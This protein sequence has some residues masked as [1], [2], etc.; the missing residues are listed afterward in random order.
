M[1]RQRRKR[2]AARG[3]GTIGAG[4]RTG[5]GSS[6]RME[7]SVHREAAAPAS[8]TATAAFAALFFLVTL[9]WGAA[10]AADVDTSWAMVLDWAQR[11]GLRHGE[12]L[13][14]SYGPLGYLQPRQPYQPSSFATFFA[15]Q[16]LLGLG[17]AVIFAT[18]FRRLGTSERVAFALLALAACRLQ[19][20]A[21]LLGSAMLAVVALAGALRAGE[22]PGA[23]PLLTLL[24]LQL[25]ALALM[26]LPLLPLNVLLAAI[27]AVG[28]WRL[29]R[30][31][32]ALGWLALWTAAALA[33]WFGH[34]QHAADLG[35][36]LYYSYWIV[37]G[38][39]AGM[40][41]EP[42]LSLLLLG[43]AAFVAA[44]AALVVAARRPLPR[45]R[46]AAPCLG[47]L[48]VALYL[49]WRSAY[50]RADIWHMRAFLPLA[51]FV[52]FAALALAGGRLPARARRGLV[53]GAA[54]G[55]GGVL[56]AALL[57]L[58]GDTGD[59]IARLLQPMARLEQHAQQYE[60]RRA[61]LDLPLLRGLVG[62]ERIDLFGNDQAVL[63]ANGFT[64]AP[65]PV[66]QAYAAYA[67]PL[68]RRNED[69]YL[70]TEAPRFVLLSLGTLDD[71][72][73]GSEDARA[74]LALL[75]RYRP[76][77]QENGVVLLRRDEPVV[78]PLADIAATAPQPLL[79]DTWIDLPAAGTPLRIALN[80]ELSALGR[81][82]AG[83]LREP[84]LLLET[85]A[86]DPAA[87]AYRLVRPVAADGFLLSPALARNADYL[88]WYCGRDAHAVTRLRLRTDA[89]WQQILF[90]PEITLA[91]QP[92]P[93]PRAP[94]ADESSI[95]AD[96][97]RA[98]P[99]GATPN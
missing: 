87:P 2:H 59:R 68:L 67:A 61:E 39:A 33:L 42:P 81:V 8:W 63:L 58:H 16:L 13:V 26:K 46:L 43:A 66:F 74:L 9:S 29:G 72:A 84:T 78:I 88:D 55:L 44:A 51:L 18:V 6:E 53:L 64:Y 89:P 71:H 95:C 79:I 10:P 35:R 20:D 69:Y 23:W 28:L 65:R 1:R 21:L 73:P 24:A 90:A 40:A 86:A 25:N 98:T 76:L 36:Y 48:A 22:R 97:G 70:G 11:H 12:E 77:A 52:A 83:V 4:A 99:N 82:Y 75:R 5:R 49:A 47:Y 14:F 45:D 15:G 85:D 57:P 41:L 96:A 19:P 50:T 31:R 30:P 37:A 54:L 7:F 94:A 93:L 60:R 62:T 91:V 32:A 34:G 27:G 17:H 38:Y 80:Y 92:L 3:R 56:G